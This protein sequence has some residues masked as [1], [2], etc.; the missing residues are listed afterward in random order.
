MNP[1][2]Q[3][4]VPSGTVRLTARQ[5]RNKKTRIHNWIRVVG[6]RMVSKDHLTIFSDQAGS[7]NSLLA[8]EWI[9][10]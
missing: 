10:S 2:V 3:R 4:S 6:D 9:S 5:G 7:R 8:V 1:V